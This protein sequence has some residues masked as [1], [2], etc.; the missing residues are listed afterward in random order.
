MQ[1]YFYFFGFSHMYRFSLIKNI[2]TGDVVATSGISV[3]LCQIMNH[4]NSL[5]PQIIPLFHYIRIWIHLCG[6][7][8]KRYVQYLLIFYYLQQNNFM[9]AIQNIQKN[10]PKELI[11]GKLSLTMQYHL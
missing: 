2:N 4:L 3:R 9:P 10:L 5:Q 7:N 11:G 8:M 6:I 1:V